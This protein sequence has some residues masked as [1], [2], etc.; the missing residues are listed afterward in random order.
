MSNGRFKIK[1][2]DADKD[3]FTSL[4]DKEQRSESKSDGSSRALIPSIAP[5]KPKPK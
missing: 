5:K 1:I 3:F 2:C 4:F